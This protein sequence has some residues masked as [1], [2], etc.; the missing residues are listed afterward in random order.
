MLQNIHKHHLSVS[1]LQFVFSLSCW[2][3]ITYTRQ[4]SGFHKTPA[5]HCTVSLS[6]EKKHQEFGH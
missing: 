1:V 2:Q 4:H 5:G 6:T 3:E